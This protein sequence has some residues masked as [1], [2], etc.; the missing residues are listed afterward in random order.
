MKRNFMPDYRRETQEILEKNKISASTIVETFGVSQATAYNWIHGKKSPS[1]K[2]FEALKRFVEGKVELPFGFTQHGTPELK[3]FSMQYDKEKIDLMVK[4]AVAEKASALKDEFR[5][6]IA[7][8]KDSFR[9]ERES[10]IEKLHI[11]REEQ[12]KA[13]AQAEGKRVQ[14]TDQVA[15]LQGD[16]RSIANVMKAHGMEVEL[17][18]QNDLKE[19]L[20]KKF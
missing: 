5:K 2:F 1:R 15:L 16:T 12:I 14:L 9:K 13:E 4:L 7:E 19:L 3:E 20:K 8:L 18:A 17:K 10:L 11:E 6:E